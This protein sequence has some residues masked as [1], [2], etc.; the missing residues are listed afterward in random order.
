MTTAAADARAALHAMGHY[1]RRALRRISTTSGDATQLSTSKP[2]STARTAT[3]SMR[4]P[5]DLQ[6]LR[7]RRQGASSSTPPPR[8]ALGAAVE[9]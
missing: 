7:V 5:Q 2:P 4:P 3:R 1:A 6:R 8:L 9:A